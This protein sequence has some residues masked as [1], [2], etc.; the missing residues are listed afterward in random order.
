M[1]AVREVSGRRVPRCLPHAQVVQRFRGSR[2]GAEMPAFLRAYRADAVPCFALALPAP[3]TTVPA[4]T[5]PL[6]AHTR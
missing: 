3:L 2:N 5:R 6:P 1:H 4:P